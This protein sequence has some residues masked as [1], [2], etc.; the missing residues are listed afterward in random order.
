MLRDVL[1]QPHL[2][3]VMLHALVMSNSKAI[4]SNRLAHLAVARPDDP[5]ND[6]VLAFHAVLGGYL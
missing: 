6:F 4:S 2:R 3:A 1:G 5:C